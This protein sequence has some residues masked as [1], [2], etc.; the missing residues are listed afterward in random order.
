[1]ALDV[2]EI[3]TQLKPI[4][5]Q[6]LRITDLSPEQIDDQTQLLDGNWEIDSVDILQL[7]IDI[8]RKFSIKLVSGKFDRDV[9]KT[10][11]TLAEAVQS[12][13]RESGI[14]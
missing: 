6:S 12:K 7:I 13:I 3:K 14:T 10:L 5:I 11:Q 1:M 2:E 9:W 4:I 8:E